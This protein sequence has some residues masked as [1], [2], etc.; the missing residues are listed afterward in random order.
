MRRSAAV[1][2]NFLGKVFGGE[3]MLGD[4]GRMASVEVIMYVC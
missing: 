1:V 4:T 2:N 3:V